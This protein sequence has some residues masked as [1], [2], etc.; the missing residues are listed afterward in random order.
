LI[1]KRFTSV[2]LRLCPENI[3]YFNFSLQLIAEKFCMKIFIDKTKIMTFKGKEH[4]RSK[5]CVYDKPIEQESS[6][7]YLLW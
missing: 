7:K 2:T 5:I 1:D 3:L 6:F 4:I